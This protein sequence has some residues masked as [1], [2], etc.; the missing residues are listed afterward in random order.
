[1]SRGTRTLI[2]RDLTRR[3]SHRLNRPQ[4]ECKSWVKAVIDSLGEMIADADPELRIELRDFGVFT[5]KR[6]R[7]KPKAR[8]PKTNETVMVPSRRKTHFKPGGKIRKKLQQPLS[9]LGY[10]IPDG[11]ADQ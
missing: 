2:R 5:V 1:M 8:N 3:V 6:T 4:Y 9:E 7:A 11:S 10:D